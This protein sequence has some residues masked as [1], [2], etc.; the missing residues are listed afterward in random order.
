MRGAPFWSGVLLAAGLG[1]ASAWGASEEKPPA[2][3]ETPAKPAASPAKPEAAKPETAPAKSGT[4]A[5]AKA[6][7]KPAP[8]PAKPETPPAKPAA[9]PAKPEPPAPAKPA[10]PAP[11][12]PPPPPPVYFSS[13]VMPL[14]SRL[15]CNVSACHGSFKGRGGLRFSL[16]GGDAEWDYAALTKE[17]Y[18]RRLN[19][20]EPQKS[21]LLAKVSEGMPHG[22]GR[23]IPAGTPEYEMLLNWIAQGAPFVNEKA[24]KLVSIKAQPEQQV[25]AKGQSQQVTVTAVFS[26][27][28]QKDV[29]NRA[30][31]YAQQPTVASVDAVG[32]VQAAGFGQGTIVATYL[33]RPAVV[34]VVV[35]QPLPPPY[36][37]AP[38]DN[39]IDEL[40]L[41]RLKQLG[42]PP[43]GVCSDAEF[44][45]R[46][47]LDVIGV[48]PTA[49]EARA[50]FA[51]T[52]PQKRAKTID[53]LLERD[54][55]VDFWT[56]KWGD[57]LR[58][59]SEYPVNVWPKAVHVYYRWLR[60]SMARNKPYDQFAREL[61]TSSGSNFRNGA[62]N[63]FRAV[64]TRDA[65]AHA[66]STALVFMGQRMGCARCH[67]H[68]Q[69]GW[70]ADDQ[71]NLGAFFARVQYKPTME[72]KEEIVYLNPKAALWHPK[73]RQ[74]V[75]PRLPGGQPLDFDLDA[76]PRE[77]L[78]EWLTSPQ[79]PWFA[80]AIVNRI[81]FWLLG[82]GIVHEPDDLRTTNPPQ[83]PELLDYLAQEL[84]S[85]KFDLKHVYRLILNSRA[86]QASSKTTQ[87]N[88]WDAAN[89]SHY[90]VRRLAA[91][92]LLDIICEVTETTDSFVSW[93]PVPATI[94]PPGSKASQVFDA[95]IDSPFLQLFG[96]PPRDTCFE[97][98]RTAEPSMR[99]ALHL[100]AAGHVEYKIGGSPRIKRLMESKKTDAEVIDEIYLA[101]LTR[102]PTTDERMKVAAYFVAKKSN[103]WL[104][105][106]DLFWVMINTNEFLTNH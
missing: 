27:G 59:K 3:P 55:Y 77:K 45:R 74:L 52:D 51:D 13:D 82:R 50:F 54:E 5:P 57:L 9:P 93:I 91:E 33:C 64:Q 6:D 68:P 28:S 12:P 75:K 103:R 96:R 38:T 71:L 43:S 11:P 70:T 23:K 4:A 17:D 92:Q 98:E 97:G 60:E 76:D 47:C 15:G 35:P 44:L 40:V 90:P 26:D 79:N 18:G 34:R 14:V 62:C 58:I 86:Y 106:Q 30:L 29:T 100:L 99:Q 53:R 80:K 19:R 88:G 102:L 49:D 65:P 8:T 85:H 32:R 22:G 2:K 37:W 81:W 61:L 72:W 78:A 46:V 95:D 104:A 101:T 42:I 83:N 31:F 48:L 56:L 36:P 16:F 94:L 41:A 67:V 84:V 39:R 105:A 1:L 24:P 87:W 63:Y 7:A 73:T 21:L 89:F 69:E 25:L 20:V 10:P 66:E